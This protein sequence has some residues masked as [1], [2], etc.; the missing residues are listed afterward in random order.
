MK[1]NQRL[2]SQIDALF[3]EQQKLVIHIK[4][5]QSDHHQKAKDTEMA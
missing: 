1:A 4:D 3:K 2:K 5:I